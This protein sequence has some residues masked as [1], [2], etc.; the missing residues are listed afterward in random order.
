MIKKNIIISILI[1]ITYSIFC[2]YIY[3]NQNIKTTKIITSNKEKIS[4]GN[5][6]KIK[7]NDVI[8][9]LII[10]KL[11]INNDLFKINSTNNNVNKNITI[12]QKSIEPTNENSIMFI[13]AHSGT[14]KL[15]FFK[16]LN[17]LEEND[18][19]ILIYKNIKYIYIVKNIFEEE[20]NGYINITKELKKQLILT[21][22]SQTNNDKQLIV[23]SI[24]KESTSN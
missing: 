2:N 17:K 8:G 20:K 22:C 7:H 11:N 1:I 4:T 24:I 21:T 5:K 6:L 3:S 12:L 23:N 14:G 9:K 16:N 19:I 13:A 10:R 18:E 15:A